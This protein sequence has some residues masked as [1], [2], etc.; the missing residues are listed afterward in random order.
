MKYSEDEDNLNRRAL[1]KIAAFAL[2]AAGIV[3]MS[4][5]CGKIQDMYIEHALRTRRDSGMLRDSGALRVVLCGT[6]SPQANAK[7]SQPCTL[8]IA[9]GEVFLFDAGEN[10]TR[11]IEK[12]GVPV[13]AISRAFI[14]HWHS[15]HFS[16]LDGVINN[17]WINGRREPFIVYGPEGADD[18]V[19]GFALAYRLDARYRNAHFVEHPELA[20]AAAKTVTVPAGEDG[21]TVYESGGIRIET[22]RVD[23]HP[24]ENAVGY[25][26]TYRGRKVFISGDTKVSPLYF[27]A[28]KDADLVVHEA[29]NTGIVK[30]AAR[31]MRTLNMNAEADQ[32]ERILEYHADTLELAALAER[33]EVKHLILTHLIPEPDSFLARRMFIQGMGDIYHG[34]LTIGHDSMIIDLPLP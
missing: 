23:H 7:S 29:V 16:G 27:R 20:F 4:A 3:S 30:K 5:S 11:A 32:A 21:A 19:R 34:K 6:G 12:S 18:V 9:G 1:I 24:V 8:V 14:T 10:A 17:S 13:S 26:L 2:M 28:M 31:C 22:Y 15:D 25:V 33:A